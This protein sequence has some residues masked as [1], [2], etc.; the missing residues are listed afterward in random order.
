LLTQKGA[1]WLSAQSPMQAS[2]GLS[3][4][5]GLA[6]TQPDVHM[7]EWPAGALL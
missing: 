3:L 1:L 5:S 6:C 2:T 4:K 7:H